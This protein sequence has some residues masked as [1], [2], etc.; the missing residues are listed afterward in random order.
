MPAYWRTG[1]GRV[2]EASKPSAGGGWEHK[3]ASVNGVR[4]HYVTAGQGPLVLLLHGFPEFWYSW[5]LQI[6]ALAAAGFRVV[7]PD[8]RGYN[9][10]DKPEGVRA[11]R[12][13]T[14]VA[15]V[16]ALVRELGAERA[17]IVGH[18]WGGV[19]A[20]SL[21]MREPT[22]VDRLVVINAPHP[23][24]MARRIWRRWQLWKSWYVF[25]FQ[26]PRLP[27]A[28][29]R[30]GRY[31]VLR[32]ALRREPVRADAFDAAAIRRYVEAIDRPGALTA[33]MNYYRAAL[34]R[35][36]LHAAR[37]ARPVTCPTLVVWG[38][39]DRHLSTG[40]LSGLEWWAP[41]LRIE[42]LPDASHW[43]QRDAPERLN[44]ILVGFLT[45]AF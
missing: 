2:I 12:L 9:L 23:A 16:A 14:L 25:V 27:E 15:D 39:R 43:V 44:E 35:N 18:D 30:L 6:P 38:E 11:Y 17:A 24:T 37:D 34:R 3:S 26:L 5:A 33:G 7:A 13:E 20:W 1:S 21:A 19:I 29:F 4:L 28:L 22:V 45:G 40:L 36:P 41:D 42:R 8:L 31:A 10:S 32:R